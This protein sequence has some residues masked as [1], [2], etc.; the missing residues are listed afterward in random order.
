MKYVTRIG[1][2][3]TK[4]S[5]DTVLKELTQTQYGEHVMLIHSRISTLSKA[6]SHYTKNQLVNN[7]EVVLSCLLP[8]LLYRTYYAK[9]F[10][11]IPVIGILIPIFFA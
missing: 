1:S 4:G 5:V 8:L 2:N 10:S 7:N 3:L 9:A 6:Y 11:L